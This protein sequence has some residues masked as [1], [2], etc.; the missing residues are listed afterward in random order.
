MG[1]AA[2]RLIGTGHRQHRQHRQ[3]E[4]EVHGAH[5]N[6]PAAGTSDSARPFA[7]SRFGTG[8]VVCG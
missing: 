1:V 8:L 6:A 3:G 2:D 4:R 7:T 5:R